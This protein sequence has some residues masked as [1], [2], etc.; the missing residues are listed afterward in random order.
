MIAVDQIIT[1]PDENDENNNDLN[2]ST[3]PNMPCKYT[4]KII[5]NTAEMNFLL[6][7]QI[8]LELHACW[9]PTVLGAIKGH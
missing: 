5:H 9:L 1:K 2:Q 7:D 3:M 6:L 4:L 8:S